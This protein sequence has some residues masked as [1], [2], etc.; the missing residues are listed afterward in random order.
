MKKIFKVAVAYFIGV[1]LVFSLA[2]RVESLD[3]SSNQV[4]DNYS[5]NQNSY[6]YN[7]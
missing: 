2:W 5:T 4:V 7:K 1:V 3:N 6:V